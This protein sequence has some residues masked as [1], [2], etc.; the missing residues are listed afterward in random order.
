MNEDQ[1]NE[2]MKANI[3]ETFAYAN[4]LVLGA[5]TGTIL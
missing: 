1:Y 5:S 4:G 3:K 2:L